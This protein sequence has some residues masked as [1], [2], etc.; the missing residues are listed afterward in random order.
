MKRALD[1][2][3]VLGIRTNIPFHQA[4]LDNP[5]FLSGNFNTQFIQDGTMPENGNQ[6]DPALPEI[7]ALAAVL[8]TYKY[9]QQSAVSMLRGKRDISNWKMASRWE[10]TKE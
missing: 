4:L 5:D 6:M 2:Y 8:A 1:E 10:R 7:A 3:R 9:T